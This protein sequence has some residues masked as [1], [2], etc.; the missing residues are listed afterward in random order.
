MTLQRTGKESATLDSPLIGIMT[1]AAFTFPCQIIFQ[2]PSKGSNTRSPRYG[3][4][5]PTNTPP[6]NYGAKQQFSEAESNE[7]VLGKEAKKYIQQVLGT[8]LYYAR[9]V[10]LTMLAALSAIAS[11][12][13]SP[14]QST[15]KKV[16]QF[17]DY[18][19]TCH[20]YLQSVRH[21]AVSQQRCLVHQ[22]IQGK[23]PGW[24]TFFMSKD[25]SFPT[26][27]GSVLNIAQIMKTRMYSA[28]ET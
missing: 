17:L 13:A 19:R 26:N 2:T 9:A 4:A 12:Q 21:G 10:D 27:N 11:E 3:K 23:K 24:R 25:V 16:E 8:F 1:P 18:V 28:E 14:T 20:T 6:P 5:L 22:Q 7:P 15:M